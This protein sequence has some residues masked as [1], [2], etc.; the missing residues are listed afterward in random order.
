LPGSRWKFGRKYGYI[1]R[2]GRIVINPRFDL[3]FHF[4]EGLAA[5]LINGKW[6]YIDTS[7]KIVIELRDLTD[8]EDFH[9]GLASVTTKDG[10]Y[11]YIDKSGKYVWKPT[12]LYAN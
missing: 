1:D 7:G 8:A 12:S 10:K 3:T 9:H 2:V 11:G 5:V 6:G 4:S